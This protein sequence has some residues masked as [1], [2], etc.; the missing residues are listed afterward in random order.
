MIL[1][2][3]PNNEYDQFAIKVLTRTGNF[4]GYVEKERSRMLSERFDYARAEV[5][6]IRR[7]EIPF[8]D[9]KVSFAKYPQLQPRI[10]TNPENLSPSER[11]MILGEIIKDEEPAKTTNQI[12][13]D[14]YQYGFN[15]SWTEELPREN[16]IRAKQ[17]KTGDKLKLAVQQSSRY[18]GR[19]EVYTDDNILIGFIDE[20]AALGL[21]EIFDKISTVSIYSSDGIGKLSGICYIPSYFAKSLPI[22]HGFFDFPYKEVRDASYIAKEDPNMALDMIQ[23][24]IAHEKGIYAK[25][26][27]LKCFWHLKDWESRRAMAVRMLD[28]IESINEDEL[29][30][31]EY[32]LLK[33]RKVPELIKII[34]T[35]DKRLAPKKKKHQ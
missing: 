18:P 17:C 3:E 19:I 5:A 13:S 4:I 7:T 33:T 30:T 34:E 31:F 32:Q 1:Q 14:Y 21:A 35:C 10:E 12:P 27:A 6:S 2:R 11:M 8:I 24:A 20:E 15:I 26:V 23:Y 29:S 16:I 22:P 25:E 28:T 9:I